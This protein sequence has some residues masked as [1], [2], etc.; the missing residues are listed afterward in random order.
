V[1]P[2]EK[3]QKLLSKV[4]P[5]E[6][7]YDGLGGKIIQWTLQNGGHSKD[8]SVQVFLVARDGAVFSRCPDGQTHSASGLSSWLKDEIGKYEKKYPRT[9][10]RFERPDMDLINGR[11]AS[12]SF[13]AAQR[14]NKPILLYAGRGSAGP[15]D[16]KARKEVKASRKFEK[17]ALSS[18]K[19]AEAARG[20][21]LFQ[22][23]LADER[24]AKWAKTK[25]I[26]RAP[27]LLLYLP[28]EKAPIDLSKVSG[29]SL[30]YH[31]KKHA[32]E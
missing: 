25:G 23:D 27:T 1:R 7:L 20:Y 3:I 16:R 32:P 9:A 5:V 19:A 17:G 8:P 22:I 30:A 6:W 4:E 21:V 18:T 2:H 24:Q 13:L 11:P 15:K 10:F 28:G 14:G 31:L 26:E 29:N 12:E